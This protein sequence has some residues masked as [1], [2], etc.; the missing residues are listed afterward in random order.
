M[1]IYLLERGI[2]VSDGIAEKNEGTMEILF[3]GAPIDGVFVGGRLHP[4]V[5]GRA[6]VR[7]DGLSGLVS[8]TA[9]NSATRRIYA[10]ENLHFVEDIVIPI[11]HFT[12]TEYVAMAASAEAEVKECREKIKKLEAAVYGI[13]LFGKEE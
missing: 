11:Q 1:K 7:T 2:G 9:R 10:C 3:H 8:V 13:P 5:K 4:V 6:T 12:P